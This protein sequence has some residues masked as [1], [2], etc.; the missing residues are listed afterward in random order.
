[1]FG[2]P[3]ATRREIH[4]R[5]S[6][7]KGLAI[8]ASDNI[9][10]SA[11]ATEEIMRV[12][13][14][15][16]AG[17]LVLSMPLS[18]AI[19]VVLMIVTISYQQTIRAY[20]QGGGSYIVS[21]DNLGDLPGLIAAAA[22]LTDYILTVAVSISAGVAALTSPFPGLLDL[23]VPIAIFAI[24]LLTS[25]NLRGI[26][27][28]GTIFAAP[29]YVYIISIL[30]LIGYGIYRW[31]TNSLPTYTPPAD[32]IPQAAA[33]L[34]VILVLRAFASGA[35]ALTGV[36][37]VANGVPAFKPPES[38][39]ARITLVSMAA[40]FG[41]LFLGISF[42]SSRIGLVPDPHE[43]ETLLSQLTRLLVGSGG[44]YFLIQCA[45][46][47][48][49]LLAANTAFAD[50][51]RLNSI[52]ARD[53]F[54][55]HQFAFRDARLA[56]S[57]GII[58]LA[59][60]AGMLVIAFGGSVA[61]LIPLY[62]VGVFLAFTLSQVGMVVHWWQRRERGW[63]LSMTVNGLGAIATAV[64]ALEAAIVKFSHGAWSVL[65]LIPLLVIVM[66]AIHGHYREVESELALADP[67]LPRAS[68]TRSKI[69]VVPIAGLNKAVMRTLEYAR[70]LGTNVTAV[71]MTDNL[72][73][74]N[75]LRDEWERFSIDIPLVIIESP[76][77]AFTGPLL[78]YIDSIERK[79]P[80]AQVTVVLAEFVPKHWWHHLLHNQT[81]LRLKA[82]LLFRPNTVVTDI[83]YH[84]EK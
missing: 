35:V 72:D 14:L 60:V 70:T 51:P 1:L 38:R 73:T 50:F 18:I 40:I 64:V 17:A 4:E 56:F 31:A 84:L 63:R 52:L 20:P 59:V 28:S 3:I 54:L 43:A 62:T 46:A 47:L 37:A 76:Y 67:P 71:H 12:L 33:P 55:P 83:P 8:F 58:V 66:R 57:T 80:Q 11:Y 13:V 82:A 26:R 2:A 69:V 36:E 32:W 61:A 34:G 45:T 74:A 25:G 68:S 23:R 79:N 30:G 65:V 75:H 44:I 77:R 15:A 48:I 5:L 81:A 9:S 49:L 39:N 78:T 41:T 24:V 29:T 19:A 21:R 6:K 27:E 7:V 22:L 10:S 53:G 16:G 42:L